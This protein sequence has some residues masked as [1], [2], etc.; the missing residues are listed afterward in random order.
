MKILLIEDEQNIAKPIV[1]LLTK[2][3]YMVDYAEDGAI[4]MDFIKSNTYDCVLLDLNLPK[5]DGIEIAKYLRDNCATCPILML[6]ARSQMYDKIEGF[7]SGADDYVTKPFDMRELMARITAL[8]KRTS[9]N[10]AFHLEVGPLHLVPDQNK[11]SSVDEKFE[12]VLSNKETALLEYLIRNRG[13]VVST[14]ELLEHVWDSN[15]NLF[16]DTVKTHVKTLRKKMNGHED[17]I[18]TI[19][20]KGYLIEE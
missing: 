17:L 12:V 18:K 20:G 11:L 15:I 8:I 16:T 4:G 6:T 3:G 10:K 5:V 1:R 14:E 19:K 2:N 13:R 7:E 9:M